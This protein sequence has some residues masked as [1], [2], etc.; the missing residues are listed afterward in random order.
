MAVNSAYTPMLT[1]LQSAQSVDLA[2]FICYTLERILKYY[3]T[4]CEEEK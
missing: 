3:G 1:L 2:K 4:G